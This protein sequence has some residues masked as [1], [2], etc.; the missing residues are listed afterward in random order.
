MPICFANNAVL[1][2]GG[3][4]D[5]A[6]QWHGLADSPLKK[7]E[8][9]ASVSHSHVHYLDVSFVIKFVGANGFSNFWVLVFCARK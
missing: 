6:K 8:R 9:E 4:T 2:F 3:L 5:L 7:P 1:D